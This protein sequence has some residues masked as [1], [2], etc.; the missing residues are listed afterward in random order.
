[1]RIGC[2]ATAGSHW[3]P[4]P[5]YG[6]VSG[7]CC[8]WAWGDFEWTIGRGYV[9]D[10]APDLTCKDGSRQDAMDG[11]ERLIIR[12]SQVEAQ[13]PL[14]MSVGLTWRP[15]PATGGVVTG[16]GC[17][18]RALDSPASFTSALVI[19]AHPL[20]PTSPRSAADGPRRVRYGREPT[21]KDCGGGEAAALAA[22]CTF[23]PVLTH[24]YSH[25]LHRRNSSWD[26]TRKRS[27]VQLFPRPSGQPAAPWS[28]QAL[29]ITYSHVP[30]AWRR[31][32][33]AVVAPRV[34]GL[35]SGP[36]PL[37]DQVLDR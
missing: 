32:T 10:D 9:L 23:P 36:V 15:C 5:H 26:L 31:A 35:P 28:P 22:T 21:M 17:L 14:A 6:L 8:Q 11:G 19:H 13:P 16:M 30:S 12:Q 3:C 2:G 33:S 18:A 7:S 29:S 4:A 34:S 25:E 37:S 27:E 20:H 1:M 24:V